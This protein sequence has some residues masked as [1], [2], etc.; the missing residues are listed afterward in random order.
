MNGRRQA[1]AMARA[2]GQLI[3]HAK[4]AATER[5]GAWEACVRALVDDAATLPAG[6]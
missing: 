4:R 1:V 3:R 2:E 6:A 5:T